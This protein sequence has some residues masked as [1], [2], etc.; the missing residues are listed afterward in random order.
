[1]DI[2]IRKILIIHTYGIGDLVMLTPALKLLRENYPRAVIDIFVGEPI[3]GEVLLE[4]KTVNEVLRFNPKKHNL[5]DK[6]K[7]IYKLR[8]RGYDLSIVSTGINPLK[9]GLFSFL[10][11]AK[12]RLGEYVK[13]KIP[14]YTLQVK[15]DGSKHKVYTN[16]N[17]LS[18][19]GIKTEKLPET[20]FEVN[21]ED[22]EFAKNFIRQLGAEN[23]ILVGFHPGAGENQ[24]FKVW[25]KENFIKLGQK[26]LESYKNS[27]VILFGGPREKELCLE[28]KEKIGSDVFLATD[29]TLKQVASLIDNCKIFVASDSGL[30]HI[31]SATNANVISIFGPTDYKR[32]VPFSQRVH[33]IKEKCRYPYNDLINPNYDA[34]RTH[35]CLSKITP[36][37]VFQE[38]EK[39]LGR[40]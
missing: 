37:I 19:L 23:K 16:L 1:M 14:F 7:F 28:I 32:S 15:A 35:T 30:G 18:A 36:E 21:L 10:A 33:L 11:G 12:Q 4:N 29:L 39:I 6:L 31:S 40:R 26:I 25:P 5:L 2:V 17:L 8:K 3:V 13:S 38:F 27:C 24:Q 9:G 22:I 34:K 20:F